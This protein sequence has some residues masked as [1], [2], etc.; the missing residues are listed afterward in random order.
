[1]LKKLSINSDL[2][3][4]ITVLPNTALCKSPGIYMSADI[5]MA[6]TNNTVIFITIHKVLISEI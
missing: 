5:N 2:S 4:P 1:M 3:G 6:I